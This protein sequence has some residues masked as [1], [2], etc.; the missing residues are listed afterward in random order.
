MF[1]LFIYRPCRS[2]RHVGAAVTNVD[3]S[4]NVRYTRTSVIVPAHRSYPRWAAQPTMSTQ[5]TVAL[6]VVLYGLPA[7]S[8]PAG[9]GPGR[10]FR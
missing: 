3:M 7:G 10:R 2:Q 8:V 5:L 9:T 4:M 1:Y 6:R